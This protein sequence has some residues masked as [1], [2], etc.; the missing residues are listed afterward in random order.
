MSLSLSFPRYETRFTL[1]RNAKALS[2]VH[3]RYFP[4]V[5]PTNTPVSIF[6]G[7]VF[8]PPPPSPEHRRR[9]DRDRVRINPPWRER[10]LEVSRRLTATNKCDVPIAKSDTAF[11][12]RCLVAWKR[13]I[14]KYNTIPKREGKK[15]KKKRNRFNAPLAFHRSV[16][17]NSDRHW[18]NT[19][20]LKWSL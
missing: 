4:P 10:N 19:Q 14:T 13:E 17:F 1:W 20:N 6:R 5:N 7:V 2:F 3:S 18:N 8:P 9:R 16:F 11:I 12:W 15:N